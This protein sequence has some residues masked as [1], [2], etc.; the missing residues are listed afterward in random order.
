M[1]IALSPT[2]VRD[3][4]SDPGPKCELAPDGTWTYEWNAENQLTRVTKDGTEVARFSYDPLGRRVER[5]AGGVTHAYVYEGGD[6]LQE[7]ISDGATTFAYR[8]ID[9]PGIDEPLAREDVATGALTYYHADGLGSIVKMTDQ[10]GNVVHSYQYD[11]WGNIEAGASQG[12][13]AFTGREWDPEMGLAVPRALNSYM[14]GA[15]STMWMRYLVS[16]SVPA[17]LAGGAAL[18]G[19][20]GSTAC[21]CE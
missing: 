3:R 15:A 12:G 4:L 1:R 18:G 16:A 21:G 9:G 20:A 8:Y 11:A 14:N 7:T 19:W 6:I 5:V 10:A 17:S 13:Y 2:S